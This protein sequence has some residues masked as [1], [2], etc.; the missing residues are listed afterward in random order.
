MNVLGIQ[1]KLLELG[2]QKDVDSIW[3]VGSLW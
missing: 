2:I 1:N 3:L